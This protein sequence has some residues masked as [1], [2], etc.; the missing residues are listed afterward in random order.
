[1]PEAPFPTGH[2]VRAD[3]WQIGSRWFIVLAP[4]LAAFGQQQL[5]YG[6]VNWACASNAVLVLYTPMLAAL[7][8]VAVAAILSWRAWNHP[9]EQSTGG[10]SPRSSTRFFAML[11]FLMCGM[12]AAVIIAQ[13]LPQIFLHPCQG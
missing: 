11:G 12:S 7:V 2:D 9:E 4:P 6:L 3:K 10:P 5:A 13:S 8:V 1:M